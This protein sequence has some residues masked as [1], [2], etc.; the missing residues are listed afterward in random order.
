MS[1]IAGD[2]RICGKYLS[3]ASESGRYLETWYEK[4]L[5]LPPPPHWIRPAS[6]DHGKFLLLP[7]P[8]TPPLNR[9]GYWRSRKFSATTPPHWIGTAS[10]DHGKFL[11]LPPPP[12][13][14]CAPPRLP[15][16]DPPLVSHGPNTHC[17]GRSKRVQRRNDCICGF[18][19]HLI[20]SPK[21]NPVTANIRTVTQSQY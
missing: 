12:V 20:S 5:L 10:G 19:R 7:P 21:V 17:Q 3:R 13:S 11:L 16:P 14:C 9:D 15:A 8:P 1:N 2:E 4:F 6:G 18:S